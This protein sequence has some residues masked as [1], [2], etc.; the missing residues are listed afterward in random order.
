MIFSRPVKGKKN[1]QDSFDGL[2]HEEMY[3]ENWSEKMVGFT[4]ACT[5]YKNRCYLYQ[6]PLEP[7]EVGNRITQIGQMCC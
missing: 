1:I 2:C 5:V 4:G 6:F 7:K 3:K